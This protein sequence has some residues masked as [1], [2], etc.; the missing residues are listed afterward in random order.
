MTYIRTA[1][2]L[3]LLTSCGKY[4]TPKI[5]LNGDE[6]QLVSLESSYEEEGA[7]ASSKK[8]DD[9][10]AKITITNDIN[11]KV[12]GDYC[13]RYDVTDKKGRNAK[14]TTRRVSVQ[15]DAHTLFGTYEALKENPQTIDTTTIV[16]STTVNN[17]II[18]DDSFGHKSMKFMV[19][20]PNL[21][22]PIIDSGSY[23]FRYSGIIQIQHE[24]ITLREEIRDS[25]ETVNTYTYDLKR[26]K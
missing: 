3:I 8:G 6:N 20:Y 19:D 10:T 11:T 22:G 18:L 24:Q 1:F 13:V 5:Q 26:I 17:E 23:T 15:N 25:D 21:I 4:S 2:F 14:T 12:V 16:A 7:T 9:L